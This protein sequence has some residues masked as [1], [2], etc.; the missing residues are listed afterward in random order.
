MNALTLTLREQP[1][2]ALDVSFLSPDRLAGLDHEAI[3]ALPLCNGNRRQQLSGLFDI[4]G[5]DTRE[6]VIR[7][8]SKHLHGIGTG[9]AS[10]L[11][12]IEGDAGD[13]LGQDMRGGF[14]EVSGNAGH[15][16]ASGMCEGTILVEGNC[17]EFAG[18]ALPGDR[19][20]MCGG[21]LL[22]RG[23]IG[24]RAGDHLRRGHILVEGNAGAYCGSRMVAGTIVVLGK[25]G[26]KPGYA[27]KRGTLLLC[28]IPE[29]LPSTFNDCGEHNLGFLPLLINSFATLDTRFAELCN[30][31][32][33]VRRYAGDLA[34]DGKGEVLVWV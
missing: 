27:M 21:T 5:D 11:I 1:R 26:L 15:W 13:H 28:E 14:I 23:N 7:N 22:V 6:L 17:G 30:G 34:V 8:S 3:S 32:C 29:Q 33:R 10:G 20:G 12:R 19:Q 4:R 31:N 16:A 24:D 18:G 25:T 2:H 9:M